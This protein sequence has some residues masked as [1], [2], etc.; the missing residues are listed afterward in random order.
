VYS[1]NFSVG[2][3]EQPLHGQDRALVNPELGLFVVCD[4][5][6]EFLES[7]LA[8]ERATKAIETY[9]RAHEPSPETLAE[10]FESAHREIIESPKFLGSTTVVAAWVHEDSLNWASVGDS[11][12]YLRAGSGG[13][14]MISRDEGYRNIVDNVLGD[15]RCFYGVR[16]QGAITLTSGDKLALVSDG[17]TGDAGADLLSIGELYKA[18]APDDPQE[19]ADNLVQVAR[20]HDDR[21]AIVVRM[22][23][24]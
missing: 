10:A 15:R 24:A 22:L 5:L 21:T 4:G 6:G 16:Q 2:L 1:V 14:R 7:G 23:S 11:R 3:A 13:I 12:L 18:I 20:K 8:A 19:A 17:I 9:C